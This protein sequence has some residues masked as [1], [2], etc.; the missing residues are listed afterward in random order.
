[1]SMLKDDISK[2]VVHYRFYCTFQ[3]LQIISYLPMKISGAKPHS[4]KTWIAEFKRSGH[5]S[6][7]MSDCNHLTGNSVSQLFTDIDGDFV[8]DVRVVV[9]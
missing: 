9:R 6:R 3:S 8:E 2:L 7:R 1:M 5:G 4:L